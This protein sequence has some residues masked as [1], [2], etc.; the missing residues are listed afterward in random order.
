MLTGAGK[1]PRFVCVGCGDP[2][3]ALKPLG[4]FLHHRRKTRRQ[5]RGFFCV[6]LRAVDRRCRHRTLGNVERRLVRITGPYPVRLA[7]KQQLYRFP[8]SL[9]V[10]PG[11]LQ[12]GGTAPPKQQ[13][14]FYF[15]FYLLGI[16]DG[17]KI[18]SFDKQGNL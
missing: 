7:P 15:Y 9:K 11:G 10:T 6:C 12:G 2:A 4:C 17:K 16:T 8:W 14:Y 18:Q 5:P 1:V 3:K 13:H